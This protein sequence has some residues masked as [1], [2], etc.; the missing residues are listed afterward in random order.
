MS[1]W[2]VELE[3]VD[4]KSKKF[5]RARTDGGS[6]VVNFGRIGTN[7]QNKTKDLGDADAAQAELDKLAAS[8]RKKG[9]AD[10]AGSGTQAA[11]PAPAIK[12]VVVPDEKDEAPS[13]PVTMT[14]TAGGRQMTLTMK[15]VGK[16]LET[17]LSETYPD[18]AAAAKA[19]ARIQEAL[20]EE[21]Y[22]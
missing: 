3:L 17:E 19:L 4:G 15:V 13:G 16:A 6:L 22:R 21:G 9:Y 1:D 5:W 20:T 14:Y 10:V 12:P 2:N 18:E 7:G 8:K 11:A